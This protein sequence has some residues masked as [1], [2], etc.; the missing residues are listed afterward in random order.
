MDMTGLSIRRLRSASF[1]ALA[2]VAGCASAAGMPGTDTEDHAGGIERWECGDFIYGCKSR[3]PVSLMAN[4]NPGHSTGTV[5]FAGIVEQANFR[6]RGLTRRWDWCR[7][8]DDGYACAF[9][10]S[11]DGTGKYYDFS[12]GARSA[13]ASDLFKCMRRPVGNEDDSGLPLD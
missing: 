3:C 6:I 8:A 7:D 10:L 12:G 11:A 2:L 9:V 5:Q 4:T 13:R 1:L